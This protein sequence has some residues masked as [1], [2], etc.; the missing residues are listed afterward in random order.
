MK[1]GYIL[2]Q[3][4]LKTEGKAN[5]NQIILGDKFRITLLTDRFFR[6]EFSEKGN[7][8]DL[9]SQIFWYR[10]QEMIKY[11]VND[12]R[13]DNQDIVEIKTTFWTIHY[14]KNHVFKKQ[15]LKIFNNNQVYH[16]GDIIENNYKGTAR[17]LDRVDGE[18]E[19]EDGLFSQEGYVI[20][21]DTNSLVFN[22]SWLELA[23]KEE[24]FYF[25]GYGN[26]FKEGLRDFYKVVGHTPLIPKYALG[27]W[28]SRYWDYQDKEL[29]KLLDNFEKREIPLSVCIIDMDWHLTKIDKKYG[30]PW[31]G[32]T[33]DLNN[34]PNP[35]KFLKELK[36]RKLFVALNLHPA[37]GFRAFENCY[38]KA[39]TFM[40]I[41]P[42]TKE[43][44]KFDSSDPRF[45]NIYFQIHH[46]F[47]KQ[48]IDFWWIDWQQGSKS[49]VK[50][51][52]PLWALNHYHFLDSKK[53]ENK[54]GFI[55]SRWPG[56]G[57]NRYPIGFSGDT[58]I[59]W[60]S[61]KF[62]PYFTATAS[63]VGFGWWSHD[64]GGHYYGYEDSEMY[65]RWIQY[66]VFSPIMRLHS[67]QSYYYKREPW[68]HDYETER[69]VTDYLQLR[70]QLIPYI[71][72]FA[73]KHHLGQLPLIY[74][75]YYLH[76]NQGTFKQK[77]SYYFGSEL[78]VLPFVDKMDK[79]LN[80]SKE[81]IWLPDG[82]WFDFFKG[83]KYQGNKEHD[84]YGKLED[85]GLF[86]KSG[87]IIPLAE[88]LTENHISL[89]EKLSV[90][91]F[92]FEDNEFELYEDDGISQNYEKEIFAKTNFSLKV[93]DKKV[94]FKISVIDNYQ[95]I[96]PNREY[97][98][99]FRSIS[100]KV[101]IISAHKSF[102][103]EKTNVL[104]IPVNLE[105]EIEVI[106]EFEK[107]L[108][109]L[110][111]RFKN[112][113]TKFLDHT[114]FLAHDLNL[115][116]YYDD[117]YNVNARGLLKDV[118]NLKQFEEEVIKLKINNKL[119]EAVLN[120]IKLAKENGD[121]Q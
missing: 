23:N 57:G 12:I 84:I 27:N 70:H 30:S 18:V 31:T 119:K 50:G 93:K 77:N 116:G 91:I 73:Y 43:P 108:F 33:W 92:P 44:V 120:I 7:F 113:T 39:A 83:L 98:L 75:L 100:K 117:E 6:F 49:N 42:K 48:G 67:S 114:R 15:S 20:I 94:T 53:N 32:Y 25:F 78:I 86:A 81:T 2:P 38:E 109:H 13:I 102:Y 60:E 4:K 89:P 62:Q 61:L 14:K 1:Q 40:G 17:T 22:N 68:R 65:T 3:F 71:Y 5:E 90:H 52:D 87:A 45:M 9:P 36:E 58:H 55:F 35:E 28:W 111:Y 99:L 46:D 95:L 76:N 110:D 107:E 59:T 47:E 96:P 69:I 10:K 66:G 74:P 82:E 79:D 103:D 105:D 11:E 121:N 34:F 104:S 51:L 41:D 56:L 21:D 19:L 24:D 63:N 80:H 64:I 37:D 118:K 88:K 29:T 8:S 112:E 101:K 97:N 106:L 54:R 85:I 16:H 72:T 115:I 26:N